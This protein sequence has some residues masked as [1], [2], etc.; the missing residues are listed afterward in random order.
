MYCSL[1][2]TVLAKHSLLSSRGPAFQMPANS[3]FKKLGENNEP[4]VQQVLEALEIAYQNGYETDTNYA[5]EDDLNGITFAGAGDPLVRLNALCDICSTFKKQRHGV[6]ITVSTLA[7][8]P[9]SDSKEVVS[10]LESSGV[11]KLSVFLAA[12][13]PVKYNKAI[14]PENGVG[15]SDVCNFIVTASEAGIK[16]TTSAIKKKGVNINAIRSL[17]ESLGAVEF[18]ARTYHE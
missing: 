3:G 1:T 10:M 7:L 16:V 2:D 4:D 14:E 12:E 6:P 5:T 8:V 9:A 13:N 18:K 17:S 11:E 15:F